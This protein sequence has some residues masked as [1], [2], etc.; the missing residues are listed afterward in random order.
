[1]YADRRTRCQVSGWSFFTYKCMHHFLRSGGGPCETQ[2]RFKHSLPAQHGAIFPV[3]LSVGRSSVARLQMKVG[4]M[5]GM[6]SFIGCTC[7]L[8]KINSVLLYY[9]QTVYMVIAVVQTASNNLFLVVTLF[10]WSTLRRRTCCLHFTLVHAAGAA[11][12]CTMYSILGDR[13]FLQ[14]FYD[15]IQNVVIYFAQNIK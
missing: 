9:C 4:H 2:A 12:F 11:R 5:D 7:I 14:N 10:D 1:M 6:H 8:V 15:P 3:M 13:T